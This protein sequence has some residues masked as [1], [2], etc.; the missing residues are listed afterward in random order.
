MTRQEALLEK[1]LALWS[2]SYPK[3]AF[4][5]QYLEDIPTEQETE[6]EAEEWFAKLDLS[7]AS[8]V[9]VYGV[10]S[11]SYY[12]AA[13]KWLKKKRDRH[14][15]FLEDDLQAVRQFFMTPAATQLLRDSQTQLIHFKELND[16]ESAFEKLYWDYAMLPL[17]VTASKRYF[18]KKEELFSQLRHKIAHD[19]AIK[20]ALVDEYL[21]FGGGFFINFYQNI[22]CLPDSY[23]GSKTYGAFPGVPAIICGAGPSL[24]KH[25]KM[26]PNLI[27]KALIFAGGSAMNA[28]NNAGIQPHFGA[29]IDPNP[30]QVIRL[31]A[32]SAE[33]VPFYYRNRMHY[34]AFQL[35]KGPRLYIPG[36]G[37][38]DVADFFEE[39]LGIQDEFLDEGHNVVNFCLQIACKLRCNPIIFIGMDLAYT[40]M[41]AYAPGIEDEVE[42]DPNKVLNLHDFDAKPILLKDIYG[43]P[44]HTLWKWV[45]ESEWIGNFAKE[46]PE[47]TLM[48]CTEGGLGFPDVPN[49]PLEEAAQEYLKRSYALPD[50]VK[51]EILNSGMPQVTH[52]AVK[53]L[54][55][56]LKQSLQNCIA[57]LEALMHEIQISLADVKRDKKVPLHAQGGRAA[58]IETE[59][60]EEEGYK[61]ILEIFNEVQAR[62]LS[63]SLH[64]SRFSPTW[65]RTAR[66]MEL[67]LKR[68]A[69]LHEAARINV[70]LID[71]ALEKNVQ[72][73]PKFRLEPP[74]A[75]EDK[76]EDFSPVLLP[77]DPKE[78]DVLSDR[79]IVRVLRDYGKPPLECRIEKD[80]ILDGQ[81]LLY[82]PNGSIKAEVFYKKGKLHGPSTFYSPSGAILSR[83]TYHEGKMN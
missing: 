39:K 19:F 24:A 63:R 18:S 44:L 48:N 37:G 64:Q 6:S 33:G 46:H 3:E 67:T 74:N 23:L 45:A 27:D 75:I 76:W 31:K 55:E 53:K 83:S 69:F 35:I 56:E 17:I 40:D 11:G 10:G 34:E 72:F 61:Y 7:Y 36:S 59:L 82:Y 25:L 65:R 43:K 80:G 66:R 70:Y 52:N 60:A 57:H 68:L 21:R 77:A 50:R 78:G 54:M 30:A 1:N 26:L 81:S 13:R 9:F 8:V 16:K 62:L 73:N 15:V 12:L 32:N 4:K 47:T 29:G 2:R 42:F 71:K 58:L 38:Y 20:N 14:L 5:I 51:G 28:L 79:H 49:R 22:H 41:K